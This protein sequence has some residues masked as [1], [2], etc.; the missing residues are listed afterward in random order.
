MDGFLLIQDIF[1]FAQFII[2]QKKVSDSINIAL[3]KV[4]WSENNSISSNVEHTNSKK[5]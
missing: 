5:S 2:E 1:F 4:T 3:E